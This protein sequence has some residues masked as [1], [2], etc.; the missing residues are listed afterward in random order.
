MSIDGA[1]LPQQDVASARSRHRPVLPCTD[2]LPYA[3]VTGVRIN[4]VNGID[5]FVKGRT[6][7]SAVHLALTGGGPWAL[8]LLNARLGAPAQ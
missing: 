3:A 8:L 1:S 6:T 2:C 4:K 7:P 5:R